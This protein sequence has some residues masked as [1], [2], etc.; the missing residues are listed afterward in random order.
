MKNNPEHCIMDSFDDIMSE[1]LESDKYN[2]ETQNANE[3]YFK[4][5]NRLSPEEQGML[6][7]AFTLYQNSSDELAKEALRKGYLLGKT[8]IMVVEDHVKC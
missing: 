7:L 1:H 4:L 8:S 6:D 3:V 5:R 2:Q